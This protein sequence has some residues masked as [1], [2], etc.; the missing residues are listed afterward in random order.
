MKGRDIYPIT[1]RFLEKEPFR[2][3]PHLGLDFSMAPS[4]PLRSIQDGEIL[5]VVD[6]GT[7]NVGKA[8][9]VK[10]EDGK[11]AIYGHLS[12]ISCKKGDVV[13]TGDLIGYSGNSG[14]V[15]GANGGYHLHFA[16]KENG[17]FIDPTPYADYIQ[18]MNNVQ[19]LKAIV[20]VPGSPEKA[21]AL[22]DIMNGHMKFLEELLRSM[23]VN[24]VQFISSIDNSILVENIKNFFEF[25]S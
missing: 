10:W 13:S 12:K 23:K 8:V 22:S 4:T 11:V 9:F 15:V 19:K 1:S 20:E 5:K 3:K 18:N 16:I 24:F 25:F 14:H 2:S 17:S 7:K 6:Y 21:V